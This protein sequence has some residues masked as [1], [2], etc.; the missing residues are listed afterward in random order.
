MEGHSLERGQEFPPVWGG[1]ARHSKDWFPLGADFGTT[2]H[3]AAVSMSM[4]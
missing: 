1:K 3:T 4:C 2:A